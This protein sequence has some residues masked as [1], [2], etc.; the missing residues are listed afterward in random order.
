MK[1]QQLKPR[2]GDTLR[3]LVRTATD[4]NTV[5]HGVKTI[6]PGEGLE[7]V[8]P[9]G[10]TTFWDGETARIWDERITTG[11]T[12]IEET[13]TRLQEYQ[14]RLDEAAGR[15][16]DTEQQLTEAAGRIEDAQ[17]QADTTAGQLE[18]TRA[19]L[20]TTA[21]ELATLQ[22]TVGSVSAAASA[23]QEQAAGA[24]AAADTAN[25]AAAAAA[26]T[27]D[28]LAAKL[29]A[30]LA[31]KPGLIIDSSF[32]DPTN[33]DAGYGAYITDHPAAASG[34][35]VLVLPWENTNPSA[36]KAVHAY[37]NNSEQ[38]VAGHTY[39]LT[40]KVRS[41]G[42]VAADASVN[43]VI[44]RRD[45]GS[46]IYWTVTP[47]PPAN[48]GDLGTNADGMTLFQ[49]TWTAPEDGQ[50][51]EFGIQA[52]S[53]SSD[54]LVDELQANDVTAE[55]SLALAVEDAK[56]A[57]EDAARDALAAMAAAN[58]AQESADG[59]TVTTATTSGP[60]GVGLTAGDTHLRM[61]KL[62]PGGT[63]EQAWRW[64]GVEWADYQV[65]SDFVAHLDVGRLTGV[66]AD[67]SQ[68]LRAGAITTDLLTIGL[69]NNLVPN[70]DGQ[71]QEGWESFGWNRSGPETNNGYPGSFW[72]QA[73][74]YGQTAPFP[75]TPGEHAWRL[76]V[77]GSVA[78]SR[79]YVQ[80]R[81]RGKDGNLTPAPYLVSNAIAPTGGAWETK[82]GTV[83]VPPGTTAATLYV[84]ANHRN[85]VVDD[86]AY[87]WFTGVALQQAVGGNAIVKGTITGEHIE[88]QSVA[89]RVAEFI[90]VK[91]TS[92]EVTGELAARVARAMTTET[93]Q[94]VV[95]GDAVIQH[96][97]LLGTT[98]A[99][100]LNVNKLIRGR[101]AIIDGSLDVVQLNVTG[102]MAAKLVAAMRTET[103]ELVVTEDAVMQ[104]ATVIG[105]L[106]TGELISERADIEDLAARMVT[107]GLLQTDQA[108][109]RGVK[110]TTA[111]I[112]GWNTAGAETVRLN[113]SN[114]L[115]QGTFQTGTT[116]A[117]AR[118]AS[119]ADAAFIAVHGPKSDTD[120]GSI[121]YNAPDNNALNS[122]FDVMGI[123]DYS[124]NRNNPALRLFPG[125]GTFAFQGRWAQDTDPVKFVLLSNFTGLRAGEYARITVP[126]SSPFPTNNSRRWPMTSV[127]T[128]NGADVIATVVSQ[129]AEDITINVVNKSPSISTGVLY[130]RIATFNVGQ[131]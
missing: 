3:Q 52:R 113:G 79:Y 62:T 4:K 85:G 101:D 10:H 115:L 121:V 109:N 92:V 47:R 68:H 99:E 110:I 125:R 15:I 48:L 13:R 81:C 123:I 76:S 18:Q 7:L 17:Q 94:L 112:R 41:A 128:R 83:T 55:A 58:Q 16:E 61:S 118:I 43:F 29:D 91:A 114:N 26:R 124:G 104:H 77:K 63:V 8:A 75:I 130:V 57:A 129:T 120:H 42:P 50:L 5:P 66:F 89:A 82:E 72:L 37:S 97:T 14:L 34:T 95:T 6:T 122:Y 54:L 111:G 36:T 127:E 84:Y 73:Q 69:G 22:T 65:G 60:A 107:S 106:V 28:T 27:A 11:T 78:G 74:N 9:T 88:G 51:T 93:K 20:D 108:A 33:W 98:V 35:K 86:T 102:D 24:A 21:G 39:R 117:R 59:K 103:K 90:Q 67:I 19:Q 45:T 116:G 105:Q 23:A 56:Q 131:F 30:A 38:V 2:P 64:T 49:A 96:A 119:N 31:D 70:G 100:E 25:E 12:A 71:A 32:E 87:Q 46:P 44:R 53:L 40:A 126:Y 80:L 1:Y